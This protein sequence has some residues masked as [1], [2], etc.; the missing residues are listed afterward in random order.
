[1]TPAALAQTAQ[2][3]PQVYDPLGNRLLSTLLAALPV[4]VLLGTLAWLR[5]RAHTAALL[6]LFTALAVAVLVFGMPAGMALGTAAFGAAYGLLP[7]GWIILNLMFLYQLTVQR[8]LFTVLRESLTAVTRD[9]RLQLLLVA[10]C[11][12]AFFEGASGFGTPVA[13]SGAILMGLGFS[14]LA[15][16]GLSLIAN[17]AP[18]AFGAL[19]TPIIALQSVTDLDL[20]TLSAMAGRQLPLFSVIVPFW[21]VWAFAGWRGVLG[22]WPAVL[23]A[24]GA[25]AVPQFLI[26]NLHG[27][28]LVDVVSALISMGAVTLFLRAWRPRQHWG[29]DGREAPPPPET[30]HGH[31]SG[32]VLRAWLPWIILSVV[33][34]VWGLPQTKALLD[35]ISVLRFPV[36]GLHNLVE[37]VPPVVAAPRPE[38]AVYLLNWLS[39]TG[40]G[41]LVAALIAALVMRYRPAE[42]LRSYGATLKLVGMSLLTIAAMLALGFT[43]RYA[44]LDA[45]L[46][47]AFAKTGLLYPFFGT[48]LGWLGVALTG[49]DTS[50]NVLFGSL[51]RITA[52]QLGLPPTLMA[53][54][55]SSGGV[56]GKMVDAQSIVVASTATRWY[57]HEGDILRYV[58]FHSLALACLVG[59]L[60]LL[61]AYVFP[62][63]AMVPR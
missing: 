48:L 50:S 13:V 45:T 4:I 52:E 57:G 5:L 12:G 62:F 32:Q 6:G 9:Q 41:I 49:S 44:G 58:F 29:A 16:S 38:A 8:G 10:F 15:A 20:R 34:F 2:S 24:G 53:A 61:Q 25:F 37:R 11:F 7:I 33:V 21:L 23:V 3:W 14:P 19:G 40:T 60:V 54:A 18:V 43:T 59:L 42:L 46:G 36:P 26:S 56:M 47:L 55:N 31:S 17:T 51:Q 35:G 27:P 22:I 1:M 39:A 30:S 63:T 28:W